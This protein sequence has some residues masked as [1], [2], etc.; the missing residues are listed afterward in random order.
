M[1]DTSP[2]WSYYRAVEGVWECPLQLDITDWAAFRACPMSW[3]DRLSLVGLV[4]TTRLL[5]PFS[6]ETSVD[7]TSEAARGHVIHTTCVARWGFT[8]MRSVE[9][10]AL[11]AN[12]R[13]LTMRI[14]MRIWPRLRRARLTPASAARVDADGRAATYCFAWFGTEM[15]QHAV[16]NADASLVTLTQETAFSRGVQRLTRRAPSAGE[17]PH[18]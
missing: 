14:E 5:G 12:G 9:T 15:R 17:A 3:L 1:T 11:A 7:A 8:V 13:D 10:L 4:W 18:A 6:F 2:S 16:C